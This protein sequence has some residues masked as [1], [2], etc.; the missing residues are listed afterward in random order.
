MY[1][2][3]GCTNTS[4]PR[5]VTRSHHDP[6]SP[7]RVSYIIYRSP[8]RSP[9][10]LSEAP[11]CVHPE[12]NRCCQD[13]RNTFFWLCFVRTWRVFVCARAR[14]L[15]LADAHSRTVSTPDG[16]VLPH[17]HTR[18]GGVVWWLLGGIP[19]IPTP[20]RGW[21]VDRHVLSL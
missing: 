14:T 19:D 15:W 13:A 1:V 21:H 12:P 20:T 10:H 2:Y 16:N 11:L 4:F 18:S 8:S 9:D 5:H 6:P 17:A 7:T 3:S